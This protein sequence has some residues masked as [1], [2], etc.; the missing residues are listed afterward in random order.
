[1]AYALVYLPGS[2][3]IAAYIDPKTGEPSAEF[4]QALAMFVWAW[5]IVSV[6]FTVAA[7]R[8]SWVLLILLVFVDLTLIFI[9]SGYMADL[10]QL[11]TAASGT[12]FVAAFLACNFGLVH[13]E[14]ICR[15]HVMLT[16]LSQIGRAQLDSLAMVLQPS[17]CLLG[18]CTSAS[19]SPSAV[20]AHALQHPGRFWTLR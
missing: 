11:L 20:P 13:H 7:T 9:A 12:G 15:M 10:P 16:D 8:S 14:Q 4:P 17:T 6:I 5:F 2:G 18:R 1:L 3:I 19:N